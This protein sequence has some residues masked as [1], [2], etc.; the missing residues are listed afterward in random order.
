MKKCRAN[1][2]KTDRFWKPMTHP[3]NCMIQRPGINHDPFPGGINTSIIAT[4]AISDGYLRMINGCRSAGSIGIASH[5]G[6]H[7]RGCCGQVPR[8]HSDLGAGVDP[9][10][11]PGGVPPGGSYARCLH[12]PGCRT[13]REPHRLA[14]KTPRTRTPADPIDLSRFFPLE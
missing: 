4:I 1:A 8:V 3:I 5:S 11:A 7:A 14:A 13:P 6:R 12:H 2:G 10:D 9:P